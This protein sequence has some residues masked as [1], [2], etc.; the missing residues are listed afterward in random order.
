MIFAAYAG[1]GKTAL[2]KNC[3]EEF[4]DFVCMP[5]KYIL[6]E[7][8]DK[9]EA[10]KANPDNVLRDGWPGNYVGAIQKEMSRGKHLLIPTDLLALALL[11]AKNI[12]YIICYP[13]REAREEYS[14]RFV[15][16]GNTA[17]FIDI[18]IGGWD[19]FLDAFERDDF[20]THLILEPTAFLSDVLGKSQEK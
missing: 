7:D 16:R 1:T 18:F 3:P 13:K 5:Y 14:R 17:E 6:P 4:A 20:G 9:S 12:P 2:A 11:R 15:E 10:G 8:G 19:C